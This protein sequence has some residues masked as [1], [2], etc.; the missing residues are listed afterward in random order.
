M[1]L[2]WLYGRTFSEVDS[3]AVVINYCFMMTNT[4]ETLDSG[5][6]SKYSQS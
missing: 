1:D 5:T 4:L 3:L 6:I 2:L